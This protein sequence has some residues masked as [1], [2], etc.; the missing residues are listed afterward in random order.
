VSGPSRN[1]RKDALDLYE[2]ELAILVT[3]GHS[4]DD[5]YSIFY[6]FQL[7]GVHRPANPTVDAR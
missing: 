6:S 3:V 5:H 1:A 4:L 7:T 2:K